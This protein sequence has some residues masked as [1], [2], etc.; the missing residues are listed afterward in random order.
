MFCLFPGSKHNSLAVN[1]AKTLKTVVAMDT[2]SLYPPNAVLDYV[3]GTELREVYW[4]Q[5][6]AKF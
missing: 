3:F 6:I 2:T 4:L 1:F 5:K